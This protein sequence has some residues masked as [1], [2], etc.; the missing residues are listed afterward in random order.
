MHPFLYTEELQ[1]TFC[2][3]ALYKVPENMKVLSNADAT[4]A[5]KISKFSTKFHMRTNVCCSKYAL[6]AFVRQFFRPSFDATLADDGASN[7]F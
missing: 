3:G 2:E 4:S 6:L 1:K 5:L 7:G